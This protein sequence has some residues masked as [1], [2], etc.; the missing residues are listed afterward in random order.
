[1]ARELIVLGTASQVPTRQR[2]HNGYLLRWDGSDTLFDPGEGTQRQFLFAGISVSKITRICITHFHGDH[3]LGLPGILQR[4]SLDG[5]GRPVTVAFPASGT[6]Y[7]ERLRHA[8]VFDDRLSVRP[9]PVTPPP[10]GSLALVTPAGAGEHEPTVLFTAALRHGIDAVGWR[11]E[12]PPGRTML[13]ERLEAAG[14]HGPDVSRLQRQGAIT[15]D[16][17]RVTLEETSIERRGQSVAFVMDT[18]WCD[19]AAALA[20]GVDLLVCESTFAGADAA[21]AA[22]WG[23]LTAAEAGRLAAEAGARTLVL[24]HFSQRYPDVTPLLEEAKRAFD[25]PVVAATDLMRVPVPPRPAV[26]A[27]GSAKRDE[28]EPRP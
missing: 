18:G 21:L 11:I 1:M 8:S 15:A 17:R 10:D 6:A 25:G 9:V 5:V 22:Q 27:D 7:F 12:E 24:T 16:G 19:G 2:N 23:H 20:R 26:A 4:L 13:P 3:C 14:V 28:R